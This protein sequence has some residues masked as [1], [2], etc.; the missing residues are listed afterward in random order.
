[1]KVNNKRMLVK[2]KV[3]QAIKNIVKE[4]LIGTTVSAII[5]ILAMLLG[6]IVE[7][8]TY[9]ITTLMI[10]CIIGLWL[11]GRMIVDEI[12]KANQYK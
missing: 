9:S 8:I 3:G 7:F 2:R 12:A 10:T 1:M 6:L 11:I 5:I 4:M